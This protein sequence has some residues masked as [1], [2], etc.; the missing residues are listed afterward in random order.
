MQD[1]LFAYT[2]QQAG[3]LLGVQPATM[4]VAVHRVGHYRGV[5]PAKTSTHVGRLLWPRDQV[6]ALAGKLRQPDRT[7]IDV[8]ATSSW[9]QS[10]GLP[11][12][13]P[14]A[15]AINV[16]LN[17]PR[18]SADQDPA[19]R[20]DE[21][22]AVRAWIESAEKR[23]YAARSRLTPEQWTDGQTLAARAV[24]AL[25]AGLDPVTLQRAVADVL[26]GR[27]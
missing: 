27:A 11:L 24:A 2:T 12:A 17:D 22:Y 7:C 6:L 13:D 8:R 4:R 3:R 9:L 20:L 14:M 21:W 5:A 19:C 18:D 25:V 16:A 15:E 26:G 23:L 1:H 10:C